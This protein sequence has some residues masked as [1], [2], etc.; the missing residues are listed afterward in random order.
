[1]QQGLFIAASQPLVRVRPNI[2]MKYTTGGWDFGW[3][4]ARTDGQVSRLL[5]NPYTLKTRR[6]KIRCAVRWFVS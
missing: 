2:P 6:D 1:L 3:V 5:Y 4:I